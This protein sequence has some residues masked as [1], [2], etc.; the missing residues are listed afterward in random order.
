MKHLLLQIGWALRLMNLQLTNA[1]KRK[2]TIIRKPWE[3]AELMLNI[4]QKQEDLIF[5]REHYK[6]LANK[7]TRQV[8]YLTYN[9][10]V[11]V[12][13]NKICEYNFALATLSELLPL[14]Q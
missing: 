6:R 4:M 13:D 5:Q 12:L 14:P 7:A 2:Q 9:C 8:Q 1:M 10:K 3:A 11:Q